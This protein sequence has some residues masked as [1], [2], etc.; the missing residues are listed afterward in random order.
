ME[1]RPCKLPLMTVLVILT[2]GIGYVQQM[3]PAHPQRTERVLR[4]GGPGRPAEPL[5][6][7]HLSRMSI[8]A[9]LAGGILESRLGIRKLIWA[10]S[11]S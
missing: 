2:I 11:F 1:Q 3:A 7:H 6:L 4:S 9:C 8:V 5:R 10:P